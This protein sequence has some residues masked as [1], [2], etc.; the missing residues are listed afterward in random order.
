VPS[1]CIQYARDGID[2]RENAVAAAVLI[3][4]LLGLALGQVLVAFLIACSAGTC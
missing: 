4:G 3:A 2:P 1:S